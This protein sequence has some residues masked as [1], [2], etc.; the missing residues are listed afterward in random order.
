VEGACK[1][2]H[3]SS[4]AAPLTPRPR[5]CEVTDALWRRVAVSAFLRFEHCAPTLLSHVPA[6][7]RFP[8]VATPDAEEALLQ[9]LLDLYRDG[10]T[11][12]VG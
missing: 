3:R 1:S 5:R 4:P 8:A 6:L 2:K 11:P 9:A 7:V 12:E 10:V